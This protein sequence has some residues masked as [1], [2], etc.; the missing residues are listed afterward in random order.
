MSFWGSI[1]L[2]TAVLVV[3]G[4][5][6][7]SLL[8]AVLLAIVPVLYIEVNFLKYLIPPRIEIYLPED[9]TL[10]LRGGPHS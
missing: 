10:R 8:Y 4:L 3:L 5:R 9:A 1:L 2:V 7:L 6:G